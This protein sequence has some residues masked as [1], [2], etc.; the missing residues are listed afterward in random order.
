MTRLLR[1]VIGCY[2]RFVSPLL[3]RA[4][5]FDPTCSAYCLEA[6]EKYGPWKG[7]YLGARRL[8]RC[9]PWHPG[10]CDLVP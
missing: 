8:L 7:L 1:L 10:G 2:R 6:V 4:C 3:P 5:R 9:H